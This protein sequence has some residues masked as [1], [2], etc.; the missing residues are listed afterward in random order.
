[1]TNRPNKN[2]SEEKMREAEERLRAENPEYLFE[3]DEEKDTP[4][5]RDI[6]RAFRIGMRDCCGRRA[7]R[8]LEREYRSRY[9]IQEDTRWQYYLHLGEKEI[10]RLRLG[11]FTI[12]TLLSI[13]YDLDV[14]YSFISPRPKL[15]LLWRSGFRYALHKARD[16]KWI[17]PPESRKSHLQLISFR[18]LTLLLATISND[19][20]QTSE[21]IADVDWTEIA[22]SL[23]GSAKRHRWVNKGYLR[24]MTE[25]WLEAAD[26]V[27]NSVGDFKPGMAKR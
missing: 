6:R 15:S 11:Q 25:E 10:Y 22:Q 8:K 3:P 23:K 14:D 1:M 12:E 26:R 13:L 27:L 17:C 4:Q 2:F 21:P 9:S 5:N 20:Y 7:W 16:P 24:K 18:Q 19:A